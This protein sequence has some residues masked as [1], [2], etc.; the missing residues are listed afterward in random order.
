VLMQEAGRPCKRLVGQEQRRT[1]QDVPNDDVDVARLVATRQWRVYDLVQEFQRKRRHLLPAWT[2]VC[3]LCSRTWCHVC[4][5]NVGSDIKKTFKTFL[6]V[7]N[8]ENVKNVDNCMKI[9][10]EDQL[11]FRVTE[12]D[13]FQCVARFTKHTY[14]L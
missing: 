1:G 9:N 5:K 13:H 11:C 3:L 8:L 12:Y 14:I 10:L 6:N 7:E 4:E 2:Q